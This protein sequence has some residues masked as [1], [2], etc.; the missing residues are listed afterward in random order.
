[1]SCCR[2]FIISSNGFTF[3]DWTAGGCDAAIGGFRAVG[4]PR[5]EGAVGW[6]PGRLGEAPTAPGGRGATLDGCDCSFI[7]ALDGAELV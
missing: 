6:T 3:A 7:S 5:D 1:M 4:G 2:F